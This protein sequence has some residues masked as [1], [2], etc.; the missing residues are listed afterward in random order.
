MIHAM[1]AM[2]QAVQLLNDLKADID[3]IPPWS[4]GWT[5]QRSF[6]QILEARL[7]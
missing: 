2:T 4:S 1:S 7:I 3:S 5:T 6:G